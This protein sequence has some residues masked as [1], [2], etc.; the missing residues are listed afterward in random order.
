M[1]LD[2]IKPLKAAK[3]SFI[4]RFLKRCTK[5]DYER[6][7]AKTTFQLSRLPMDNEEQMKWETEIA[8]I[9][10]FASAAE[11]AI[12]AAKRK[13]VDLDS[14]LAKPMTDTEQETFEKDLAKTRKEQEAAE[15]GLPAKYKEAYQ[16]LDRIKKGVR[17]AADAFSRGAR[18]DKPISK[19]IDDF[20]K[21]L[22]PYGPMAREALATLEGI[23]ETVTRQI[24]E[25]QELPLPPLDVSEEDAL[26]ALEAK[27]AQCVPILR[28]AEEAG[29]V[30]R[31][32][33]KENG[34]PERVML[35]LNKRI[36]VL[37]ATR[38]KAMYELTSAR[39]P[40]GYLDSVW[41]NHGPNFQ[42]S[43]GEFV[44][45]A[46]VEKWLG[47]LPNIKFRLDQEIENQRRRWALPPLPPIPLD[48]PPR[49]QPP[50]PPQESLPNEEF[51]LANS[52]A[53]IN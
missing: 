16:R 6:R 25:I 15:A 18:D 26:Q 33:L 17:E 42:R 20:R 21:L 24:N 51:P 22:Q 36:T 23:D 46:N 41:R 14:T 53:A 13:V 11:A 45:R 31:E 39:D 2:N 32:F 12:A 49:R 30:L 37:N 3:R 4:I 1:S 38:P 52:D 34:D 40:Q 47:D 27:Q 10:K 8:E 19:R 5:D 28:K 50:S 9:K 48:E 29:R 44:T 7:L 43:N 35:G